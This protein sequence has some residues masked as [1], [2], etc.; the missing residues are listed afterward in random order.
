[1]GR[2]GKRKKPKSSAHKPLKSAEKS[3]QNSPQNGGPNLEKKPTK[4]RLVV[5]HSTYIPGL[6]PLLEKLANCPEIQTITPAVISR[7]KSN[8]PTFRLKVSVPIMGGHKLIAR[9][10]KSAQEVFVITHWSKEELEQAIT[11]HLR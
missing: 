10:R 5:T 8:S 3:A 4:A 1:M 9:Q 7:V 2:K 6:I 11:R